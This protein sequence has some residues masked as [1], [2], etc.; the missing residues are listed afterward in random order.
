MNE[1][2][3]RSHTIFSIKMESRKL[4]DGQNRRLSES[5]D[6]YGFGVLSSRLNLVDL[7]G[8][9]CVKNTGAAGGRLKEGANINKSL[10]ALSRVISELAVAREP[11]VRPS[12]VALRQIC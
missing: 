7:A 12:I 9:E 3:S 10:L 6:D 5:S 2:S 1:K 11:P 8:S 4:V